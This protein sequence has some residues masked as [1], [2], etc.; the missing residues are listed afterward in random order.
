MFRT[1]ALL[2][3]LAGSPV[4]QA[5]SPTVAVHF[6]S[7]QTVKV[8][9][10]KSG[11][12]VLAQARLIRF[13]P[14]GDAAAVE[15]CLDV[16]F[17]GILL[18]EVDL[19][20]PGGQI[21]QLKGGAVEGQLLWSSDG[22]Y[23]IGAGGNTLR[24]W[25]LVGSRRLTVVK[26]FGDGPQTQADHIGKMWWQGQDLCVQAQGTVWKSVSSKG[27]QGETTTFAARFTVPHLQPVKTVTRLACSPL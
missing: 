26:N 12:V 18:C 6:P 22:K 24:L 1:L 10:P 19:V 7:G 23:L 2:A 8:P 11:D 14:R 3:V 16:S 27:R 5:A 17:L 21:L 20:R 9:V 25:N 4:A 15:F 13:S